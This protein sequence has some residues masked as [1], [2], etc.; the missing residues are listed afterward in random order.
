MAHIH[1]K[2]DFTS[3]VFVVYKNTV[4]LRMHDKHHFWCS[5]GGHIELDEDPNEAAIREV[6]EEVGLEVTLWDGTRQFTEDPSEVWNFKELIP[7]VALNRHRISPEH[8]HVTFVFF[9]TSLTNDVQPEQENDEWRW[10]TK[11]DLDL[12]DLRPNIR[13]YAEKALQTLAQG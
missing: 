11:E 12:M 13:Y 9:A 6:R 1:E 2:I 8:E 7:P 3:E 4:L 5:V 10:C